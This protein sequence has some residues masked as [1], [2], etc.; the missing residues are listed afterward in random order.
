MFAL[1]PF[2]ENTV[3]RLKDQF[4]HLWKSPHVNI[5]LVFK[6][7]TGSGKTIMMAQFLRDIVGDPRFYGNDVA[8]IWLTFN[9]ESYI[10][11]K[12]KLFSYYGGA[13]ELDLLDLNDLTRG[14]L[15]KN[16]VF[17]INWQ[18]IKGKSK[19]SRILRKDNEWGLTFDSFI[20]K[21]KDEGRKLVVIIDEEH[22]G[23][24]TELAQ[25]IIDELIQ[26]KITIRV[27]A[28]PK[29]IPNAED[30]ADQKGGFIQAKREDVIEAGL[31]KEKVIFQTEEDL[32]RKDFKNIDQDEILLELAY[33]KRLDTI[34]H[35]KSINIDVNPL[36]LIQ[37]PNDDQASKDT[38]TINKQNVVLNY[39]KRKGVNDNEIAIWLSQE[40]INLE[41]IENNKSQISFLLFKQAAATGWDCPRAS[42]LVMF[43]EIKNPTFAIQTVG[44]IL[45]M[46][47]G[48]HF[49]IPELNFGYLYTNYKRNEVLTE[50]SKNKTD[51]R[52]AIYGSYRKP[53]INP[54]VVE[55]VFMSRT[56]YN[57]LGDTFQEIF[58][59]IANKYFNISS[60]DSA[61]QAI[62]KLEAKN[63]ETNPI[64]T[65]GLIVSV[66]IDDY[67]NFTKELINEGGSYNQEMSQHDLE[68][69]Y[70][71]LCFKHISKQ[72]NENKKFAPERSWGKL[73][74]A[75]N[76]WLLKTTEKNRQSIYMIVVNDLLSQTSVL[77]PIIGNAL[78]KYRPIREKE[79]N[80]KSDRSKRIETIE[81][82]RDTLFFTDQYEEMKVKKSAMSPFYIEKEYKGEDNEKEFIKLLEENKNVVWWYKNGDTGSEFFSIS[83][84][85]QDENKEKLFYPDW[86][87]MT[88][89]DIWII[90]T[91]KGVTAELKDTKYKAEALQNWVKG[92]KN[93]VGGIAVKDGPNGWKIN[94]SD[95]YLYTQSLKD[96]TNLNFN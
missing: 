87:V 86:I 34:K 77:A 21:T 70:N 73:K 38:T 69:L 14:K 30:I 51:N 57:D 92:R 53:E 52:P 59:E 40:K 33:Q 36:V 8:F 79:V 54:I 22:I 28:T 35:Y 46:P 96:W 63:L 85:N 83:Y 18:K 61:N 74:T 31:I 91:K 94:S 76:V 24:D 93:F 67:D 1:K 45:R 42:V 81:I 56:D 7:P 90:D 82:P 44:R 20:E 32:N 65:N 15:N 60:K 48:S 3:A 19:E 26:P 84:Y 39:L 41:Y 64:V 12:N 62:K 10:Q 16:S 66:E 75:L 4:L 27:S 58:S 13:S 55:S 29:Y 78:E 6:S 88:N 37:L 2:Q 72:V 25:E 95:N 9:E 11:S 17:F 23:S 47:F 43:R 68:R 71:L 49:S 80:K 5:P 89:K 50:Y